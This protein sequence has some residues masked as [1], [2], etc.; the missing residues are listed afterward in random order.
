MP[1]A[2]LIYNLNT[3]NDL[4]FYMKKNNFHN[5]FYVVILLY[6]YLALQ[7][8]TRNQLFHIT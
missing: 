2:H 1:K 3:K 5:N 6:K 8:V 4:F 7:N